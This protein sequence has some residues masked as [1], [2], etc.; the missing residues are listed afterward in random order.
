MLSIGKHITAM[1]DPLTRIELSRVVDLVSGQHGNLA[2]LISQLRMVNTLDAKQYSQLKIRLPYLVC[3]LFTP[4]FRKIVNLSRSHNFILDLDH[5]AEKELNPEVLKQ[6]LAADQRVAMAFVSPGGDGLKI[7]FNFAEPCY[8]AAR[9]SIF[10]KTFARKFSDQYQLLQVIDPRTSDVSRA[11]FL[12]HDPSL[13]VN[14]NAEP[15]SID[16]FVDFDNLHETKVLERRLK[17]QERE[18]AVD[19]VKEKK[20]LPA[21][22]LKEIR[23]KLNPN[24]RLREEKKVF[25]PDE[26]DMV[27][28]KVAEALSNVGIQL[29]GSENIHYG[30]KIKVG[31]GNLWAEVNLFYGKKGYSAVKTPKRGSNEELADIAHRL[32]CSVVL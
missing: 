31:L 25:V 18:E 32:I 30:R 24:I 5:L 22:T 12:S 21:D 8:D 11:C 2:S 13:Y 29:L 10:Y 6:Q 20:Q 27:M 23:E 28:G 19:V 17:E 3:G 1:N 15:V 26:I 7:L 9:Y 4:P 16:A 14:H